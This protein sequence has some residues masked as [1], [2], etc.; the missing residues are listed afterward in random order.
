MLPSPDILNEF[1]HGKF[2][3]SNLAAKRAKQ[4]QEGAVPLVHIDSKHPLSIA[5]AEIAAG[6]VKATLPDISTLTTPEIILPIIEESRPAEF[7][8]LLP[9][10]DE[11][12]ISPF[13]LDEDDEIE[14]DPD[15][16]LEV[17]ATISDLIIE[18]DS[19]T[20]VPEADSMSL[21]DLKDQEAFDEDEVEV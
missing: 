12:E 10:L 1:E 3:L 5:L 7:N 14:V 21:S 2:V 16:E 9:S 11:I 15:A 18:D 8:V 19:E 6:K 13:A 4:I 20:V 17:A